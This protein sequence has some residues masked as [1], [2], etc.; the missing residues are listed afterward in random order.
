MHVLN[1]Q[2]R[3][4]NILKPFSFVVFS[5]KIGWQR[6]RGISS[7]SRE[8]SVATVTN[9]PFRCICLDCVISGSFF[10]PFLLLCVG[11]GVGG[12]GIF[13][14]YNMDPDSLLPESTSLHESAIPSYLSPHCKQ[15]QVH[16]L[17][18][19]QE[20][21]SWSHPSP[22]S[23]VPF[24]NTSPVSDNRTPQKYPSISHPWSYQVLKCPRLQQSTR[25]LVVLSSVLQK[26]NTALCVGWVNEVTLK[27]TC[28]CCPE[29]QALPSLNKQILEAGSPHQSRKS[30]GLEANRSVFEY[31]TH[32]LGLITI[33]HFEPFVRDNTPKA[34]ST[35]SGTYLAP[36]KY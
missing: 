23:A 21:R 1:I 10:S 29:W 12:G 17:C 11:V 33:W 34:A 19:D 3:K 36:N 7:R 20:K 30:T 35:V 27:L 25:R 32:H 28:F 9:E 24:L 8:E 6:D 2:K 18:G 14:L 13:R 15:S 26:R 31:S 22:C 4:K 5:L 16:W